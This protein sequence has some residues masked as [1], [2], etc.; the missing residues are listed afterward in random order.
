[1][2]DTEAIGFIS[3]MCMRMFGLLVVI[4]GC[5]VPANAKQARRYVKWQHDWITEQQGMIELEQMVNEAMEGW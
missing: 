1:M 5:V 3:S 4:A 2:R